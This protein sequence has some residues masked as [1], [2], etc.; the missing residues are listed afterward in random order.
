MTRLSVIVPTIGR[1]SLAA[2]LNSLAP[3]LRKGDR[4]D[5]VCDNPER[6][7]SVSGL[8]THFRDAAPEPTWRCWP[9]PEPL[10]CYGHPAR[11]MALDLLEKLED[12]PSTV[13][14]LDDDDQATFGSVD[15]IRHAIQ[16]F[17]A[18]W[19]V[20]KMKGGAGSHFPDVVVPTMGPILSRGNIGTP[21]LVWSLGTSRFGVD[22]YDGHDDGY[23]GD[24]QMVEALDKEF[25]SPLWMDNVV[26]EIRP[27]AE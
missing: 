26:A 27:V 15:F 9:T 2:T 16:S 22:V 5:V 24:F 25:G 19:Y 4:V 11:N 7:K 18:P 20:F 14:S 17:N 13:W 6:Y 3:Q 1:L 21:M 23:F 12:A 10:G 8:V